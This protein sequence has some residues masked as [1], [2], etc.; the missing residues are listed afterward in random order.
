MKVHPDLIEKVRQGWVAERHSKDPTVL[1]GTVRVDISHEDHLT[2]EAR[3]GREFTLKAD[4]P[5]ERGGLNLG[6]APLEYFLVG[7]GSC[8]LMQY[9]RLAIF[10][11]IAVNSISLVAVGHIDRNLGGG[12]TDLLYEVRV[13]S[14]E[15]KDKIL[16]LARDAENYCY[17][18][19][20]LKKAVD[21]TTRLYIN[22]ELAATLRP[23][24][25]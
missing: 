20:T 19:N 9:A 22:N 4:E 2:F 24:G 7:A 3:T 16:R 10:K 6:P 8:L 5:V 23:A 18:H 14:S 17:A 12:F 13:T 11:N 1:R 15:T 25:I 21:M